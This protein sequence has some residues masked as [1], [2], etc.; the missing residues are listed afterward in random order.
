MLNKRSL[1]IYTDIE[2]KSVTK[3]DSSDD[4]NDEDDD[5]TIPRWFR[6]LE[7]ESSVEV[8]GSASLSEV[9]LTTVLK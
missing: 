9:T 3:K 6:Q 4:A 7:C 2:D 5:E 1:T 8:D